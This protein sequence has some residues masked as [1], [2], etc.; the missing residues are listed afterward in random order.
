MTATQI[1]LIFL[2]NEL[3]D[4]EYQFF[5]HH[6][7]NHGNTF[8]KNRKH[9]RILFH[10]TFVEDYLARNNR[11]LYGFIKRLF[12]L[13]PNLKHLAYKNPRYRKVKLDWITNHDLSKTF[14]DRR[15][16]VRH[17]QFQAKNHMGLYVNYYNKKWHEFL[18]KWIDKDTI[19]N[20]RKWFKKDKKFEFNIRK[21]TEIYECD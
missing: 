8:Y 10:D 7:Y 14:H 3:A 13:A 2:K 11:P 16:I 18:D 17:V 20:V 21:I 6:L 4:G 1:F 12:V 5:M 9:N 19:P 15:G